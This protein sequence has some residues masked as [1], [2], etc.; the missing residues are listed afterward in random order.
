MNQFQNYTGAVETT[1]STAETRK[2]MLNVYNWMALGLA[3]T[4]VIAY[5]IARSEFVNILFG[6]PML[7]I[8]LFLL[9]LG[10]VFGLT[11]AIN[12]IPSGVDIGASTQET[13]LL[14]LFL[15]VQG[16][17]LVSVSLVMLLKWICPDS[18]PIF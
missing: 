13:Q 6:N 14:Q 18:V 5:G 11:F 17:S 2:F 1:F 8:V 9:Q 10:I 15:S 3:L 7:V 12:K 16:C 4:G